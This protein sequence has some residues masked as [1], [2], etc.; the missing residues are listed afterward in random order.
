MPN[1]KTFVLLFYFFLFLNINAQNYDPMAKEGAHWLIF[2]MTDN[3]PDHHFIKVKGDTVINGFNYKKIYKQKIISTAT[4]P[5]DLIAPYFIENN[6][7]IVF[8]R[9][10][11]INKQ[12]FFRSHNNWFYN[13]CEHFTDEL[14]HD[15]SLNIGDTLNT[16]LHRSPDGIPI[17]IDSIFTEFLWGKER[18][19]FQL[20]PGNLSLTEGIGANGPFWPAPF[21]SVVGNPTIMMD[22]C[23]GTDEECNL[24]FNAANEIQ[25]DWEIS[26]YP[27]PVDGQLYLN[28]PADLSFPIEI[29]IQDMTAKLHLERIIS[30]KTSTTTLAT[31]LLQSGIYV[32]SVKNEK[33]LAIKRFMK[34]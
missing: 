11:T 2:F 26:L 25:K 1:K 5:S 30:H 24:L 20:S 21:L 7:L 6:L 4:N 17:M 28:L 16:C 19:Q 15:F 29:T 31:Q 23:I 18:R 8:M 14:I 33:G 27:N 32:I 13:D 3:G 10:D 9:D 34:K 22:Y 12:V